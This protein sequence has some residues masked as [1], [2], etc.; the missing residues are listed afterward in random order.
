MRTSMIG[1]FGVFNRTPHDVTLA[2]LEDCLHNYQQAGIGW[3][4]WNL[5]GPFGVID[6]D[7]QDVVYEDWQRHK[8]DRKMLRLLQRY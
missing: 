2:F 1:E 4:L 3:A 5:D 7:R 8:L 6:S